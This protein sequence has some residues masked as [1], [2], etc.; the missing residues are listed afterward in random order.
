[1][2]DIDA[3]ELARQFTLYSESL[4]RYAPASHLLRSVVCCAK[5]TKRTSFDGNRAEQQTNHSDEACGLHAGAQEDGH[6]VLLPWD[7]QLPQPLGRGTHYIPLPCTRASS[8][9]GVRVPVVPRLN[10][11]I[12]WM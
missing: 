4:Y 12:E 7:F 5:L 10:T 3:I 2:M 11:G 6:H 1:M 9:F 8:W